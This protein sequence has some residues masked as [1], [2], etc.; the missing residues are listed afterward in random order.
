MVS[1]TTEKKIALEYASV[2][3]NPEKS[4]ITSR[5]SISLFQAAKAGKRVYQPQ[6]CPSRRYTRTVVEKIQLIFIR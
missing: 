2:T 3:G 6:L 4:R 1:T 5:T